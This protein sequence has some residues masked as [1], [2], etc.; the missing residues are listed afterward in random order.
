MSFVGASPTTCTR[1]LL[2]RRLSGKPSDSKPE[3]LG[4]NPGVPANSNQEAILFRKGSLTGKAVVPKTT[5]HSSL[6][7][8]SPVPSANFKRTC[9]SVD[10]ERDSAKVEVARSNR[11]RST[12]Q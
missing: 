8:S 10:S 7:G 11:A 6:A 12:N 5:A 4:S 1:N 3:I 2:G 9:S